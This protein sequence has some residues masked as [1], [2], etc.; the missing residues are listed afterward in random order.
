MSQCRLTQACRG[1]GGQG[2]RS[3]N[4]DIEIIILRAARDSIAAMRAAPAQQRAGAGR[5]DKCNASDTDLSQRL[6]TPPPRTSS[7]H[8]KK[9]VLRISKHLLLLYY[10]YLPAKSACI[11]VNTIKVQVLLLLGVTFD[12]FSRINRDRSLPPITHSQPP[13]PTPVPYAAPFDK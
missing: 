5:P 9:Y 2:R 1:V 6:H 12:M 11:E 13:S 3:V 10:T 4:S 8:Y 7:Q